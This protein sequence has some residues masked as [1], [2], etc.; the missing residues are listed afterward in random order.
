MARRLI[1]AGFSVRV[2]NRSPEKAAP[3]VDEGASL[4]STPADAAKGADVLITMLAD[5]AAVEAAMSGVHGALSTLHPGAVWIQMSSVGVEW[6]TRLTHLVE[7][8]QVSLVDAPVSGS[9]GPA[10]SGSLLILASGP[11]GARDVA[12]SVLDV[13]GRA[14]Y[15]L[16]EAGAGN[17]AKVVLNNLLVDQVA[18]I[19]Q[20]LHFAVAL[21]LDPG[22][23]VEIVSDAPIGSPYAVAKARQMLAGDFAPTFALRNALKDADL[24]LEAAVASGVALTLTN[25]FVES[26]RAIA[27]GGASEDDVAVVYE[28]AA[29]G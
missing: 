16:G 28:A 2:W 6:T 7:D 25:S 26:W 3:L 15:W 1:D 17:R 9:V 23:I 12:T 20:T 27:S 14:T 21:G 29:K 24:A 4:A 8:S 5:G 22:T 19:A 18:A 13:L 10:R 11:E